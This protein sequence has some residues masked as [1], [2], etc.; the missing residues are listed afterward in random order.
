[1][2]ESLTRASL[3]KALQEKGFTYRE[4]REIVKTVIN[5]LTI[6]LKTGR[7]IDTPLGKMTRVEPKPKRA[8]R[9]GKIVKTHTKPKVHF[10]RKD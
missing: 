2:G 7:T 9:F 4:A 6:A 10:R 3:R 1:M 5:S 8:Y